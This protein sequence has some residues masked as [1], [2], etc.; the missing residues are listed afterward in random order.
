MSRITEPA[1]NASNKAIRDNH[2]WV[3]KAGWNHIKD[4]SIELPVI[5]SSDPNHE[6]TVDDI[7]W[8]YM[9]ERIIELE[10]KRIAELDAYLVASGLDDYELTDEDK[11]ILSLFL[12]NP[13]LT[14][15]ELRKLIAEMGR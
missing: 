10:Q 7:D 12:K 5:E 1:Y 13:H 9:Q 3:N 15:Q 4:D 2:D 14:K 6:Y 11:E 8:Q